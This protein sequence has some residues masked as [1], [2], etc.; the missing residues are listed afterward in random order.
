MTKDELTE[1]F[2]KQAAGYD[3]QWSRLSAINECLYL[4]LDSVFADLPEDAHILCVGSGTGRELIHLA[5][6]FPDWQL[7]AVEPSKEMAAICQQN[8]KEKGLESRCELHVGYLDI[9]P[10]NSGFDAATSFLVSQFITD[11]DERREYF[12]RISTALKPG[13]RLVSTD[14]SYDRKSPEYRELLKVWFRLMASA[15]I[16]DEALAR[17]Q[18]AYENDVAVL[19]PEEVSSIIQSAGFDRPIEFFRAGMICGWFAP[20]S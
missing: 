12:Q 11:V 18:A 3:K 19:S 16:N 6:R 7:T 5:E 14:L 4:L 13:G 10:E 8:L 1:L 9:L 20:V 15:D 2:D 17:M